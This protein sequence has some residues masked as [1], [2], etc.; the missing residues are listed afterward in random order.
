MRI[1]SISILL[2]LFFTQS[3]AQ[4]IPLEKLKLPPGF[5]IEIFAYPVTNARSMVLAPKG[6]VF[7]GTRSGS[8]YAIIPNQHLPYGTEILTIASGLNTPNGVA[9][10]N[11]ALYVT[12]TNRV[13][14]FDNI[15]SHL[16]Q[17]I[18]PVVVYNNLPT[19]SH[20]GW[21]YTKFGYNGKLYIG[22]GAPCNVCLRQDDKRFASIIRMND[23][24]THV[25]I[26]SYGVRNTV[27]FDW[28]PITKQ[29]W[30]T[31]N[32]RDY[33]G[34]NTPP[35]ELNVAQRI[36]LHYGF[37]FY[38]GHGIPDPEF[39]VGVP[40]RYQAPAFNLPAHVAALG[41]TFYKG[42]TFPPEY[43]NNIFIAEHGSWNRSTKVGYQI[44]RAKFTGDRVTSVQPF[45]TGW[46]NNDT[47]WGRPVDIIELPD[48]SILISDDTADVIYRVKYTPPA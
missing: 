48:G 44:V 19:E 9:F 35:D 31:D 25:E 18:T 7:V 10:K 41:M 30:F 32:G 27:G 5:S 15:E 16:H 1:V 13:I 46:L 6:T 17:R 39:G 26:F 28:H 2:L 4:S 20:H 34:D 37:P 24:G 29:L 36:N 23:D 21:R 22:I 11:G 12:E 47:V 43:K 42:N 8:V 33:L 3:F 45:I 40:D 38:H 14:R